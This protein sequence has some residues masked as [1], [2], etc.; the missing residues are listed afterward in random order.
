MRQPVLVLSLAVSCLFSC[1]PEPAVQAV[2]ARV[3][4]KP[5]PHLIGVWAST[6]SG[7]VQLQS[8][9]IEEVRDSFTEGLTSTFHF[10]DANQLPGA[11]SVKAFFVNMPDAKVT[12]SKLYALSR[13]S[14]R[15]HEQIKSPSDPRPLPASMQIVEGSLYRIASERLEPLASGYAAIHISMPMGIPDRLYAIKIGTSTDAQPAAKHSSSNLVDTKV[16]QRQAISEIQS[17]ARAWEARATDTNTYLINS[18]K[19]ERMDVRP[20]QLG[21][22]LMPTYI[23]TMPSKDGWG[24]SYQFELDHN[25]QTYRIR[26]LGA[27]GRSDDTAPGAFQSADEDIVYSNG[28]FISYPQSR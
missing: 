27:N 5:D 26:S 14:A 28:A 20:D 11:A 22:A 7:L 15:W 6:D 16:A 25:G 4:A 23:R 24:N 3:E 18:S 19:A 1:H 2:Q 9:G 10:D 13:L 12:E 17:I 21:G 8:Y